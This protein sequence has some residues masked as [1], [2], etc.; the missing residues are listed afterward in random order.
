MERTNDTIAVAYLARGADSD[1]F[2]SFERFTKS[3]EQCFPGLDHDFYIIFKGFQSVLKLEASKYF[4][5]NIAY[6]P[7]YLEDD[8]FDIGAYIEWANIIHHDKI[9]LFNTA[10][11]ILSS[12]WLL[13]FA[14][15]LAIDDVGLVGATGSYES[16]NSYNNKFK[17]FPNV[18]IRSTGFMIERKMFLNISSR[19]A[20]KSKTEALLFESGPNSLTNQVIKEGKKV[21]LV[22]RDGRGYCPE[23]WPIS[24]T[25]RQ[26]MQK[27]LLI[28][29][30][31]T[32][33]FANFSVS[34]KQETADRTWGKFRRNGNRLKFK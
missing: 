2:D 8:S 4:F 13:K 7:V 31:Q 27:N 5:K 28:A 24:D 12:N 9:F 30:N 19:L 20:I 23:H 33:S 16:L 26:G 21:L 6:T 25:F 14:N 17:K 18:H 3:Y 32:R 15:N 10:S 29:D 11:E 34:Q 1:C 22:G